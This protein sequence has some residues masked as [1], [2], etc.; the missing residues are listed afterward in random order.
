MASPTERLTSYRFPYIPLRLELG[1]TSYDVEALVDTGFDGDVAVP[2][3][4]LVGRI[5]DSELHC[6]LADGSEVTA[7]VYLGRVALGDLATLQALVLGLG[8]EALLGRGVTDRFRL[9][10]DHGER[11]ILEP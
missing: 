4:L 6:Q 5:P 11:V 2:F 10:L 9:V 1:Q 8:T 7:P 3:P